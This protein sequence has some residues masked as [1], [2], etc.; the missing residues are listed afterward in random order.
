MTLTTTTR[1]NTS[2]R[3]KAGRYLPA[4]REATV[5]GYELE[6]GTA[7]QFDLYEGGKVV[8]CHWTGTVDPDGWPMTVEAN[9][10]E[11]AIAAA[12]KRQKHMDR[13]QGRAPVGHFIDARARQLEEQN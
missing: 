3:D 1:W 4:R 5:N 10:E 7:Y 11:A 2:P 6:K 8:T 12:A 9:T 13:L